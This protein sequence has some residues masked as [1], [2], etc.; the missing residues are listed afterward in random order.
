MSEFK[1]S[2]LSKM[3]VTLEEACQALPG[4]GNHT[5]RKIVAECLLTAARQGRSTL[6]EFSIIARKAVAE[7]P[8]TE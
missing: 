5:Q 4:G 3:D 7:L 6:G 8:R 1:P 2:I